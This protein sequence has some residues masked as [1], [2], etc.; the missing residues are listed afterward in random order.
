MAVT[1]FSQ[2]SFYRTVK[3]RIIDELIQKTSVEAFIEDV[4]AAEKRVREG[5]VINLRQTELE[6]L[7]A[8][9]VSSEACLLDLR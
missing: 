3:S 8:G 5:S 9:K 7:C 1:S 2:A 4:V 6:L